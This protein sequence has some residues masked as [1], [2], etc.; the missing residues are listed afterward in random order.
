V[1]DTVL[2]HVPLVHGTPLAQAVPQE[3]Q[4]EGSEDGVVQKPLQSVPGQVSVSPLCCIL[5]SIIRLASAP[6][7]ELQ[8][9]PVRSVD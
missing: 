6:V 2:V 9:L 4:F 8:V 1:Q 7:F 5:Y 3:P